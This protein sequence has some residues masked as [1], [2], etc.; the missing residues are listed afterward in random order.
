MDENTV[1]FVRKHKSLFWYTPE[2]K[3]DQI[4]AGFL[5]ETILNYGSLDDVRELV[6]L[7][8]IK[9]VADIFFESIRKS[10][11]NNYFPDV[12][13]FFSLYFKKYA[14]GNI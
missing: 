12:Q 1:A 6:Q 5:I 8:G 7:T 11:R 14:Y 13:N 9:K 4:S 2:E 3:L 10:T